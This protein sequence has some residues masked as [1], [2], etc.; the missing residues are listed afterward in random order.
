MQ[1]LLYG[2]LV[3]WYYLIDPTAAHGPEVAAYRGALERF[4][5]RPLETLLE[6]GAGGGNNGFH[7]K[8]RF[9]CTLTD[10]SAPMQGLSA[11]L[12]PECEHI[13][14]DM[15]SL[16]L[17]RS[18]DAVLVH[19][20]IMYM[21]TREELFA[22]MQT[23]YAHLSPGGAAVFTPDCVRED[24]VDET[25]LFEGADATRAL[26]GLEWSWDPDPSDD[27]FSVEYALLLRDASG[28]RA[29]HDRHTEGVFRRATWLELLARAGFVTET[30]PRPLDED[31]EFDQVFVCR[32]P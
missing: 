24:L 17:G 9:R 32:R 16:R 14:G 22:T 18:F 3:S 10:I 5:T 25:V 31:G 20:A 21:T 2:E 11:A 29:V 1:P 28:V 27:Q 7:L 13:L 8:P 30:F 12:N 23:A 15:R 6:L 26:R 4:A 19:D